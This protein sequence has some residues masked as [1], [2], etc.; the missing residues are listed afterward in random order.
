[1][2]IDKGYFRLINEQSYMS[3]EDLFTRIDDSLFCCCRQNR[4]RTLY[5]VITS[6]YGYHRGL[7]LTPTF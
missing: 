6:K 2:Q 4:F 1:M 3:V 7:N 5:Q